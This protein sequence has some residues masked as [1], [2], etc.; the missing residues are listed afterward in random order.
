ME[1]S[2][3]LSNIQYS[4]DGPLCVKRSQ[5]IIFQQNIVFLCLKID[6]TLGNSADRDA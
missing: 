4:P 1:I 2:I 6:F 3:K 5:A